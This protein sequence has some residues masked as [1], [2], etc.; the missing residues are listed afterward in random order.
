MAIMGGLNNNLNEKI[1]FGNYSD[2]CVFCLRE[3]AN[4]DKEGM[5]NARQKTAGKLAGKKIVKF[6]HNGTDI[7][8]CKE[9]IYDLAKKFEKEDI[10]EG[11]KLTDMMNELSE[12]ENNE[13]NDDKTGG[14][15]RGRKA[16]DNA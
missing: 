9:H 10:S 2:V 14:E 6:K 15:K 11:S 13:V 4:E 5:I 1:Q 8:I 12:E 16:K 3:K 7:V